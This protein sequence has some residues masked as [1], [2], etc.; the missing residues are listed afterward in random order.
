[1][2][3][4]AERVQRPKR[5][6]NEVV[7]WKRL[8]WQKNNDQLTSRQLTENISQAAPRILRRRCVC[9]ALRNMAPPQLSARSPTAPSHQCCCLGLRVDLRNFLRLHDVIRSA[10]VVYSLG[11]TLILGVYGGCDV[12]GHPIDAPS[13]IACEIF[14]GNSRPWHASTIFAG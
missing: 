2:R 13:C 3:S 6:T 8:C 14:S 1:M 5:L 9:T 10:M 11:A 7:L 4:V 12:A